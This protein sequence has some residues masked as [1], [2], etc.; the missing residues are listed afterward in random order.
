LKGLVD[1]EKAGFVNCEFFAQASIIATVPSVMRDR[2]FTPG[3]RNRINNKVNQ[4]IQNLLSHFLNL[5]GGQ[6]YILVFFF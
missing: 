4:I 1:G 3:F 2:L 5:I 6:H